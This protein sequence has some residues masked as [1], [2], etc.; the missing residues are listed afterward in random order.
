M[1]RK[2]SSQAVKYNNYNLFIISSVLKIEFVVEN[3]SFDLAIDVG[4]CDIIFV[5]IHEC[6]QF[7]A[8]TNKLA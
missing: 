4:Y 6:C 2:I 8:P 7:V 5:A 3:N 1:R